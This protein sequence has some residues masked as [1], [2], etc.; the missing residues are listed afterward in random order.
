VVIEGQEKHWRNRG[1]TGVPT[2]VFGS[3][4][5]LVGA[6]PVDVYKQALTELLATENHKNRNHDNE[7]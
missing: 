6:Q 3:I 4:G 1:V 7:Q 5:A 2:V